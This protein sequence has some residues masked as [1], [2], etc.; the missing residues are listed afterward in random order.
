MTRSH[1]LALPA[2]SLPAASVVGQAAQPLGR[3]L[4]SIQPP[5]GVAAFAVPAL[6]RASLY[7]EDQQLGLRGLA[8]ERRR[9]LGLI[10]FGLVAHLA[11]YVMVFA[12]TNSELEW[13]LGTA[14]PRMALH[15]VPYLVLAAGLCLATDTGPGSDRDPDRELKP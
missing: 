3:V 8:R 6:D 5:A 9:G 1:C 4:P 12:L 7:A 14:A 2:A 11:L 15:L 10:A 13:H